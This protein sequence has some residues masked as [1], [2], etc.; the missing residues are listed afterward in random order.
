[1]TATVTQFEF[2]QLRTPSED[3]QT[4]IAPALV[5]VPAL[6]SENRELT[7]HFDCDLQGRRWSDVAA[8][9]R[10][11]LLA[12]ARRWTAAYRD[13]PSALSDADGPIFLAG[14]QPQMFH[15]GVW[16][17][18]FALG[19]IAVR[20]QATA[21]N[22]II[23]DDVQGD[24]ALRVPGGTRAE[25]RLA[26][27]VFDRAEPKVAYEERQIEDRDLFASFGQRVVEQIRPLVERPLIEQFWPMVQQRARETKNLGA[28]IAQARHQLEGDWGLQTLEVPQSE[29]C[30]GEAFQWFLALLLARLP[31]FRE[32]YNEAIREYR[33]LHHVRSTSHPAPELASNGDWLEAPLWVWTKQDAR[34]RRLFVQHREDELVLADR[35]GWQATLPLGKQQDAARAVTQLIE[36]QHDSVRIRPRALIT[37]LWA[38]LALGDLFIHGIGGAKYDRVTDLLIERFFGRRPPGF[39]VVSATR[40]LPGGMIGDAANEQQAI[41][42]ELRELVYHP[43][44]YLQQADGTP[45]AQMA[46]EKRHWID[47]EQTRENARQRCRAI[48]AMNDALQPWVEERRVLLQQRER[49]AAVRAEAD[50]ILG[51]REYA[52]VLHPAE[53]LRPFLAECKHA[54]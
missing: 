38:R 20:Q 43:D 30:R 18:N 41:A 12:A 29:I 3:G 35:Q 46:D 39:M 54:K 17:K 7:D 31:E 5:D 22:L 6:V 16:F 50:R 13:V 49:Q 19:A 52:F 53:T 24:A 25:P 47:V 36:L 34:R 14:H 42:R 48:R 37:T 33:R 40:L 32:I 51:S 26:S 10:R 4:L 45:A 9:A 15:P 1:M 2:G 28:C 23:D 21:I 8:M 44:R 11:E 27:V